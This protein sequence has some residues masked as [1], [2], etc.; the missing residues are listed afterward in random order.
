MTEPIA[1]RRAKM[2]SDFLAFHVRLLF[3]ATVSEVAAAIP[4][5]NMIAAS[6]SGDIYYAQDFT[7]EII[8]MLLFAGYAAAMYVHI[9][10][11]GFEYIRSKISNIFFLKNHTFIRNFTILTISLSFMAIQTAGIFAVLAFSLLQIIKLFG[12]DLKDAICA[13]NT[14]LTRTGYMF[15][16]EIPPYCIP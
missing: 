3:C 12:I 8:V 14:F 7:L 2:Y 13:A 1:F 16:P 6:Q 15:T 11:T 5:S 9:I 4:V 10:L